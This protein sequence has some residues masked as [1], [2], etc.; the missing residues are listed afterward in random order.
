[1][2]KSVLYKGI[3]LKTLCLLAITFFLLLLIPEVIQARPGG[4]HSYSGGND[5]GGGGGGGDIAGL[6]FYILMS[7]PPEISIPLVVVIILL[8]WLSNR[9]KNTRSVSVVSVPTYHNKS[10]EL[11]QIET[12][13]EHLKKNDPN[14]SRVLFLDFITSLYFKYYGNIAKKEFKDLKPFLSDSIFQSMAGIPIGSRNISEIVI[15]N[16]NIISISQSANQLNI[17]SDINSNYTV[18]LG[19][20]STRFVLIERWN[21]S[22]KNGLLSQGPEKMQDLKC[23]NCGAPAD[24]SDTGVCQYCN[25]QI[26]SGEMQWSLNNIKIIKQEAFSAQGLGVYAQEVGTD[27]P[28]IVQP[29][30]NYYIDKFTANHQLADWNQYWNNFTDNIAAKYF[31]EIYK[32][33]SLLSW[34]K[35]RHL[36]TDRLYESYNFWIET[37]KSHQLRNKLENLKIQRIDMASI[38]TDKFYESFTVRIFASCLDYTENTAGKLIGGSKSKPRVFSEYWTFIRRTGVEKKESAYSL[39]NCPNCGAPADKMGQAAVC[40][41]CSAKISHGDF[42]WVLARIVQDE[43]YTG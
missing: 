42:S 26:Q 13:I 17:T 7:L 6:I 11:Q 28:T 15:G 39:Y 9:R 21:L 40:A 30:I 1:M 12:K 20:K 4:G 23:P 24:F 25:T 37:Y 32:N 34:S 31:E 36:L 43:E 18:T 38:E 35:I 10:A 2:K 19:G 16:I 14:F 22:R 33:W 27:Y 41:Y 3:Y 5:S 29:D 8:Y